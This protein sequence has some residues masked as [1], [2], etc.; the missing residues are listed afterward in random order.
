ADSGGAPRFSRAPTRE[1]TVRI[2]APFAD[3]DS[4]AS[5]LLV[6]SQGREVQPPTLQDPLDALAPGATPH[7]ER[8][9][10]ATVQLKPIATHEWYLATQALTLS[11]LAL[12][13]E[14]IRDDGHF[15][16]ALSRGG[17]TTGVLTGRLRIEWL[18]ASHLRQ[19]YEAES[20]LPPAVREAAQQ[21][22]QYAGVAA[23]VG[24]S[25][26][27]LGIH[28]M[29]SFARKFSGGKDSTGPGGP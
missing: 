8:T 21:A 17:R 18:P 12:G 3:N 26:L 10:R 4:E 23:E 13:I 11:A 20:M 24:S 1:C 9:R 29:R 25:A 16:L 6:D 15:Q 7:A 19:V 14:R 2:S 5:A 28:T 27:A 22:K